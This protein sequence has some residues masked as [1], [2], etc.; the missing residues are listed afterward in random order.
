MLNQ[1]PIKKDYLLIAATII[2][3]LLCYQLAFKKT[4]EAWQTNK[5]LKAQIGRAADL[6]YQPAY[7]Q[8]KNNN[9]NKIISLYKIDTTAF[10]S[11]IV[12]T[13]ASIAEKE[14]VKL[15]EVPVQNPLY[16]TDHFIIQKLNFE[17]SFFALA[18][19]LNRLQALKGI[20]IVRSADYK[21]TEVRSGS[22]PAKK[23]TLEVYL[24]TVNN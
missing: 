6:S 11:S 15:S 19:V 13:I 22:N 5:Q 12:S 7:V 18:K 3:L 17:G 16:H 4:L 24:E 1:L 2:F 9:L 14:Q 8:R 21:T 23:L 10:R 20:G